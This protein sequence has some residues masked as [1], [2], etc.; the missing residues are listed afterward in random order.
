METALILGD[1]QIP[2]HDPLALEVATQIGEDLKPDILGINGDWVEWRYLSTHYPPRDI[3]NFCKTI[4]EETKS[5]RELLETL[6]KRVKPKKRKF[7]NEGN[8]E[9][10]LFRA[11]AKIPQVLEL[12]GIEEV[13]KALSVEAV[14]GLKGL[15][16]EYS[17]EYPAG[18]WL[19]NR[20]PQNNVFV[21]H[22]YVTRKKAGY[23]AHHE[24]DTRLCSTITGHGERLACVW[25]RG[26][27]RRLFAAEGGN[28]SILGEPKRGQGIYGS[29]PFNQPEFMDRQQGFLVVTLDG[30]EIYPEP[31]PIHHGKAVFR[32]KVYKA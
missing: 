27:D 1:V 5:A 32:G 19:F 15:G 25:R 28:L 30:N 7:F 16:Y 12:M 18:T 26:L 6:T 14:L 8:H 10:R 13:A 20:Q 23:A 29:V 9:W 21:H 2:C 17:G 4:G 24:I 11:L 3:D 31:V 22:S